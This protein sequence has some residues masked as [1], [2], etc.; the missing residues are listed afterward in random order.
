[1]A[2]DWTQL[3]DPLQA[4]KWRI[5]TKNR[6]DSYQKKNQFVAR[7]LFADSVYSQ[8][9]Q[10]E[11]LSTF[12]TLVSGDAIENIYKF[13]GRIVG[14]N[15]PHSFLPDPCNPDFIDDEALTKDIIDM[16][17]LFYV[18]DSPE[19]PEVNSYWSVTLRPSGCPGAPFNLQFARALKR[20]QVAE[21]DA[22]LTEKECES[23]EYLDWAGA[24]PLR[25]NANRGTGYR[26][27]SPH[28]VTPSTVPEMNIVADCPEYMAA[29]ERNAN[30]GM[31]KQTKGVVSGL[32]Q[33]PLM[34]ADVA[35]TEGNYPAYNLSSYP[36]HT[37]YDFVEVKDGLHA[38]G[39]PIYAI[40]DGVVAGITD[41]APHVGAPPRNL[42]T[43]RNFRKGGKY[44]YKN[45]GNSIQIDQD[46]GCQA[47]YCHF[48][49][50]PGF[51]V[52]DRIEQGQQIA[53]LGSTGFSMSNHLHLQVKCPVE[54]REEYS[55][56]ADDYTGQRLVGQNA[57]T[58]KWEVLLDDFED[59][60]ILDRPI[61]SHD[62]TWQKCKRSKCANTGCG[63]DPE[64]TS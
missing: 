34:N 4:L 61:K 12:G 62:S 10:S 23:L 3:T 7:V 50:T 25:S 19:L 44:A 30:G 11:I 60:C 29:G 57:A 64:A 49:E 63:S 51:K 40:Y 16:H 53:T 17:T 56:Y 14:L 24:D 20:L 8:V 28:H 5:K 43:R 9:T 37:G 27:G 54:S 6:F 36:D 41:W 46:D 58:G 35:S 32:Y 39:H 13:R 33:H 42:T 26:G 47:W 55:T 21:D 2:L 38:G 18:F 1:M 45:S 15:S 52:G 31:G 22:E 59:R 48:E